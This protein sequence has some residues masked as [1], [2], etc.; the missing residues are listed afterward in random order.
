MRATT[1]RDAVEYMTSLPRKEQ[2]AEHWRPAATLLAIIGEKGGCVFF[3]R[4]AV[5]HGLR[6]GVK[7]DPQ[8]TIRSA[9]A[10]GHG[11]NENSRGMS[12]LTANQRATPKDVPSPIQASFPNC[13]SPR[14]LNLWV[15][16]ME[17]RGKHYIVVQG[18]EPNSWIWT[19]DLD[20]NTSKSGEA[21]T[22][23]RAIIDVALFIDRALGKPVD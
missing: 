8:N 20:E 23:A 11:E 6:K 16:K 14:P 21:K 22:R 19:V 10:T 9:S 5:M 15:R 7:D 12:D 13:S 4:M 1:L 18:I 2:N 3:A 17:Y